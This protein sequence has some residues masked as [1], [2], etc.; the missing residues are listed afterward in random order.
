MGDRILERCGCSGCLI[1]VLAFVAYIVF[2]CY[3]G[4]VIQRK[5]KEEKERK[6]LREKFIAD[7]IAHVK[8]S[9]ENDVHYQDSIR[10]IREEFRKMV[11]E[12]EEWEDKHT[13]V[14]IC[15]FDSLYHTTSVCDSLLSYRIDKYKYA[16]GTKDVSQYRLSTKYKADSIGYHECYSCFEINYVFS[17][18]TDG[19]LV[20]FSDVPQIAKESFDM[21]D[22]DDYNLPPDFGYEY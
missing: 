20:M 6:E 19:E 10:K 15:D 2:G 12:G 17:D 11:A 22:P 5:K 21:I 1:I 8:D 9:L 14:I 7:S 4:C 16:R 18:Y 3:K 13:M